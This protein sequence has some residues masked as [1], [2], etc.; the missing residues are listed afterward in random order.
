MVQVPFIGWTAEVPLAGRSVQK[1][2]QAV[3]KPF[4]S[5]FMRRTG[6]QFF[7]QDGQNGQK[8]LLVSHNSTHR[9][10]QL[11]VHSFYAKLLQ[12]ALCS[13]VLLQTVHAMR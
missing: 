10:C 5:T 7:M 13:V 2:L 6:R 9:A 4:V 8:P 1:L 11:G 12:Y 3:A